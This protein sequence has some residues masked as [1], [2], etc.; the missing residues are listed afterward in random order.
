MNTLTTTMTTRVIHSFD[1]RD[2]RWRKNAEEKTG[3]GRDFDWQMLW[4][5]IVTRHGGFLER[6][7]I[8]GWTG[9]VLTDATW[10]RLIENVV[11]RPDHREALA[12]RAPHVPGACSGARHFLW[13]TIADLVRRS[14]RKRP[15]NRPPQVFRQ[16]FYMTAP[17]SFPVSA[18]VSWDLLFRTLALDPHGAQS[19][20]DH[21]RGFLRIN[22]L[23][24]NLVA[25]ALS[26]SLDQRSRNAIRLRALDTPGQHGSRRADGP[27][28]RACG[29][30]FTQIAAQVLDAD[31]RRGLRLIN[32]EQSITLLGDGRRHDAVST[33]LHFRSRH[34]KSRA[35]TH[36][37]KAGHPWHRR[38]PATGRINNPL[39][40]LR[41]FFFFPT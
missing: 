12:S 23:A 31:H 16:S 11:R 4:K 32:K 25:L 8:P 10:E 28:H 39:R 13:R 19:V 21:A 6:I 2:A 27:G 36:L 40:S 33:G 20:R 17:A 24:A 1:Q 7:T 3:Q 38:R 5:E 35:L 9:G 15:G 41:R 14:A 29:R 26:R 34:S 30:G 18:T 37:T 22:N